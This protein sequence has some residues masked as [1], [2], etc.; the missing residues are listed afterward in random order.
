MLSLLF[1]KKAEF[2]V[3]EETQAGEEREFWMLYIDLYYY[4]LI[5]SIHIMAF[6][7]FPGKDEHVLPE[8]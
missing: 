7:I 8:R 2:V 3:R 5:V 6:P 1:E 4:Q